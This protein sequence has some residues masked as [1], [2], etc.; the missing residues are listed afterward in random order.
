MKITSQTVTHNA[1]LKKH[2]R[3]EIIN[4][5]FSKDE[6][7]AEQECVKNEE[8]F[9]KHFLIIL[10]QTQSHTHTRLENEARRRTFVLIYEKR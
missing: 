4:V 5:L 10:K 9:G 6:R 1:T 7:I 2:K 3:D 8:I